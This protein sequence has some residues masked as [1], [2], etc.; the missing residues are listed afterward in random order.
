[1]PTS[2]VGIDVSKGRLDVAILPAPAAW[3]VDNTEEGIRSLVERVQALGEVLVVLEATGGFEYPAVAALSVAHLPVA[4]VN[5]RQ[6][7]DF[8]KAM[9]KLAKTDRI[10]AAVLAE[11]AQRVQP[12]PRP[13]PDAQAQAL[14][15]LVTRRRQVS[16]MLL[17]ERHRLAQ[18]LPRVRP[19][20]QEHIAWLEQRMKR[21]DKDLGDAVRASPVWCEKVD[22][23][24]SVKGVGPV[25]STTLV[26]ELPEL[27]TLS[28]QK[29]AALVGVAPLNRDSGTY[30]GKR[31]VWGGRATVR[32]VLYM[33][34]L[35]ATRCN[36]VIRAFYQRLLKAGKAKKLA[37]TACMRKLLTILNAVLRDRRPWS[38]SHT[39]PQSSA[40]TP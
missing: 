17:M 10:D 15:A 23:L 20:I 37:L 32:P 40:Q 9:G 26:A 38:E 34:A 29:I 21:V 13:L 33:S 25:L 12:E 4:V 35:V 28:R 16:E 24:R 30:R 36:P 31:I 19:D 2:W 22:L 8:A 11:F 3:S 18:A 6:V 5:P 27:G 1:V 14:Q 7:R 39:K